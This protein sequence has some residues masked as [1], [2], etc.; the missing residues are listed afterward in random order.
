MHQGR[1]GKGREDKEESPKQVTQPAQTHT[2]ARPTT[3]VREGP[4]REQAVDGVGLPRLREASLNG[5]EQHS[6]EL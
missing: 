3:R 2:H 5:I 1:Q 4:H 6:A